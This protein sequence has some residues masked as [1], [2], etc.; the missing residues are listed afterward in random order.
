MATVPA[1]ATIGVFDGLHLGHRELVARV[2]AKAPGYIPMAVTFRDNPK[3][4]TRPHQFEGD[5]FSLEQKLSSLDA[6]GIQLCVLIDFSGNFSKLAGSEFV[7]TLVRSFGVRSFVVG[8]DFKCGHRLSTDARS[9]GELARSNGAT[10]EIVEPVAIEGEAVSSS[11]IRSAVASGRMD[12]ALAMLGRPYTLDLR[13]FETEYD[14]TTLIVSLRGHGVVE[15]APGTYSVT[16]ICPSGCRDVEATIRHDGS[17][18]W[19]ADGCTSDVEPSFLAFGP[20][21]A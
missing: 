21:I 10:A 8:S 15:P 14:G 4:L 11:R 3:K 20:K 12:Q 18:R 16:V 17:L 9:L 19:A 7:S 1:A 13:R 6:A 5:L 2:V